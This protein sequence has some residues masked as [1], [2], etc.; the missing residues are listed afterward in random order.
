MFN[1]TEC[2]VQDSFADVSLFASDLADSLEAHLENCVE[3]GMRNATF[4]DIEDTI[5][6]LS[7]HRLP[8]GNVIVREGEL[9]EH[10]AH[11]FRRFFNE[12]CD[13][14]NI[15]KLENPSFDQSCMIGRSV[16]GSLYERR[17]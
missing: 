12:V 4:F 8:N 6:L 10:G 11:N 1:W 9:E 2:T 14:P 7:G 5:E 3:E 13:L 15:K 16:L 17:I